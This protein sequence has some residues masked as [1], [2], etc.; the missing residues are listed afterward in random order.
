MSDLPKV[1]IV[2]PVYNAGK[3][4]E[5]SI[6]AVKRQSY[7]NWE[8]ILVDDCSTDDSIA[9]IEKFLGDERIKLFR[10]EKN[11]RAAAARN[12]GIDEAAGKY[13]AYLDADDIWDEHKLGKQVEFMEE[14]GCAFSYTEYEF[15]DEQAQG[16]GKIVKIKD[17]L[18]YKAALPRT[19]IFTSTV[20][21]NVD[22]LGKELI[23]MPNV[24]SEDTASWWKILRNGYKAYGLKECLTVYRRP[25]TSLSSNKKV[26]LWRIWN[27]YRN[28]EH[29]GIVSSSYYFVLWA[30]KATAR[31]L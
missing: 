17:V 30:I 18:D 4:I 20:M 12:R 14:K 11:Q 2:V 9:V 27:L 31:R 26:A 25:A 8:L 13:I 7:E 1:S 21:L 19:I 10:Q 15:G 24:P 28:V 23:K 16:T 29:L 22:I 5:E 3:Y 6:N